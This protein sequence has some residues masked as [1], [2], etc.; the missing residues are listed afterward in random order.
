MVDIRSRG[1]RVALRAF[2]LRIMLWKGPIG[3]GGRE[4][5]ILLGLLGMVA[6]AAG[7]QS[8]KSCCSCP[9]ELAFARWR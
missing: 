5:N 8:A 7:T 9:S 1:V 3:L 4:M 6:L 2:R